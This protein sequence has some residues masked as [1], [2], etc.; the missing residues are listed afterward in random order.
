MSGLAH[1]CQ[2]LEYDRHEAAALAWVDDM[3][4]I[5]HSLEFIT[6]NFVVL[7]KYEASLLEQVPNG[8]RDLS[9]E[10][11]DQKIA[12]LEEDPCTLR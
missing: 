11:L 4:I 3:P 6:S 9:E 2:Q 1:I 10:A 12:V 5:K 7:S 8:L